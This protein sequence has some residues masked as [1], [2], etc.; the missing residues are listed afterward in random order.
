MKIKLGWIVD[1][2]LSKQL[3]R[4]SSYPQSLIHIRLFP[5]YGQSYGSEIKAMTKKQ[6]HDLME[7]QGSIWPSHHTN[8]TMKD[9]KR[10]PMSM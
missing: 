5:S 7:Q 2:E 6:R 10:E 4:A 9:H 8:S 1:A 3:N